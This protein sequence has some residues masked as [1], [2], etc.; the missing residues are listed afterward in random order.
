[1]SPFK[2]Y[3][4]AGRGQDAELCAHLRVALPLV[5]DR[6]DDL[7]GVGL[8]AGDADVDGDR[9]VGER[10][11]EPDPLAHL[12][13]DLLDLRVQL[14]ARDARLLEHERGLRDRA[15]GARL[16]DRRREPGE[17]DR[18]DA[19]HPRLHERHLDPDLLG[20]RCPYRHVALQSNVW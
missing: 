13:D 5:E 18:P 9:P 11:G 8:L 19:T 10:D 12:V 3:V 17:R 14:V 7:L 20:Q 4:R 1:M 6:A 16:G 2:P 15:E